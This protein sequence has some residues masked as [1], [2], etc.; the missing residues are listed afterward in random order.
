[1]TNA[2][3]VPFVLQLENQSMIWLLKRYL[4]VDLPGSAGTS[5]SRFSS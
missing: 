3:V 4:V 1:M 5:M 2:A